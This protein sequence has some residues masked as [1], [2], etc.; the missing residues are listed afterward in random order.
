MRRYII[1]LESNLR[2]F[3]RDNWNSL[4][5]YLQDSAH[6][7]RS[8]K[9]YP[10]PDRNQNIQI[11]IDSDVNGTKLVKICLSTWQVFFSNFFLFH[12]VSKNILVNFLLCIFWAKILRLRVMELWTLL[13][14]CIWNGGKSNLF[15]LLPH[16]NWDSRY[17]FEERESV[18]DALFRFFCFALEKYI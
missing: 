5:G 3:L 6:L 14:I 13:N 17:E 16:L 15:Q 11:I 12:L 1:Y 4:D 8:C 10:V 2:N 7:S 9:W 18:K